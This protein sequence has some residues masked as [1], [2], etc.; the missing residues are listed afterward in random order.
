[1]VERYG[2]SSFSTA[3]TT[4]RRRSSRARISAADGTPSVRAPRSSRR[5]RR[6]ASRRARNAKLRVMRASQSR[7]EPDPP[8][9][10]RCMTASHVSCTAS[11]AVLASARR[12][13][14]SVR[15]WSSWTSSASTSIG[16]MVVIGI[17]IPRSG[18]SVQHPSH[19]ALASLPS[20][21]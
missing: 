21:P 4:E 8:K 2:S 5:R 12:C 14:A 10:P 13:R 6:L 11:S 20:L 19:F 15:R 1:M 7:T 9:R 17:T 3:V 18:E 16:P